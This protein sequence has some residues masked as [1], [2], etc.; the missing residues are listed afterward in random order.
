VTLHQL[1]HPHQTA[2]SGEDDYR[3]FPALAAGQSI[4]AGLDVTASGNSAGLYFAQLGGTKLLVTPFAGSDFTLG[5][6]NE[7]TFNVPTVSWPS[8]L[9]FDNKYRVVVSYEF[10]TGR[11]KLWVNPANE[12]SPSTSLINTAFRPVSTF[13]L[14]QQFTPEGTNSAAQ[15]IDNIV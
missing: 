4:Y 1:T 15:V 14:Y 8:G 9:T 12:L 10:D 2:I 11:S 6:G 13:W 7:S 5:I 3:G